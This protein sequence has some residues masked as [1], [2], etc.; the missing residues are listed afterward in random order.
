MKYIE[1]KDRLKGMT[2][3]SIRDIE[4]SADKVFYR[5]RLNEW[6]EKG[7][8]KK[9]IKGY[10]IFSDL[11]IDDYSLYEISNR[12][13]SPSYISLETALSY[14]GLIPESIYSITSISTRKTASFETPVAEF[15]YGKVKNGLFFGY[16]ISEHADNTFKMASPE[17]AV[18]DFFYLKSHLKSDADFESLRINHENFIKIMDRRRFFNYLKLYNNKRLSAS[19]KKLWEYIDNA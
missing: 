7:Y 17:K 12:I 15:N 4:K 19:I 11:K 9:L 18:L 8:I 10:Y 3:F 5:R 13:Y 6:Q 1:L 14:Y 2:V 16:E